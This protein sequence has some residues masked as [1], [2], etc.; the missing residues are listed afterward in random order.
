MTKGVGYYVIG[1]THFNHHEM[2]KYCNRP[3]NFEERLF[4]SMS[5]LKEGD[6]LFHLGDISIGRDEEV[7]EKYIIPLRATKILVRGNHDKKSNTWYLR[8]GWNF[9]CGTITD[10]LFGKNILL[11][12]KPLAESL[13]YDVNI[14]AH[15][16]NLGHRDGEFLLVKNEKQVL[17]SAE[18]YA[19]IPM[20]LEYLIN[21][22]ADNA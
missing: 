7:H 15:L 9:V 19:Y 2:Q 14:H 13:G 11:S 5:R 12:H 10:R 8:H 6:I 1:D 22:G 21:K 18:D 3:A 4:K 16:H 17:Y 20:P